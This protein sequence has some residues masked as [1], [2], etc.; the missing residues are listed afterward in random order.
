MLILARTAPYAPAQDSYSQFGDSNGQYLDPTYT[1]D[2]YS[3]FMDPTHST[4]PT[5]YDP[6]SS[7]VDNS[8]TVVDTTEPYGSGSVAFDQTSYSSGDFDGSA[9]QAGWD[10]SGAGDAV[11]GVGDRK[12]VV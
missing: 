8:W 11:S 12:S 6:S 1:P 2:A 9:S 5:I 10:A 7:T 4:S 3:G